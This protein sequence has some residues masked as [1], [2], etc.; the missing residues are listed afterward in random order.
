MA[1]GCGGAERGG[2][3]GASASAELLGRLAQAVGREAVA[4]YLGSGTRLEMEAEDLRIAVPNRFAAE[5]IER[6]M[7]DALRAASGGSVRYDILPEAPGSG[8][9]GHGSG[10]HGTG[11]GRGVAGRADADGTHAGC[12][13]AGRARCR[14]GAGSG[15]STLA[16]QR[17]GRRGGST[18]RSRGWNGETQTLEGFVVGPSNRFAYTAVTRIV[19]GMIPAGAGPVF[20]YGPCGVGKTH[21][22]NAAIAGFRAANPGSRTRIASAESFTNEFIGAIRS[23][24]IEAFHRRYRRVDLLCIDDVHFLA[25]K[26]GTQT[27]LLHTFDQIGIGG[28]R[29]VIASDEHPGR[30][31]RFSEALVSRFVSGSL[32]RIDRPDTETRGR[33]I[34]RF[35][36][37]VGVRF[38]AAAVAMIDAVAESESGRRG[39]SVRDLSGVV[40]RVAAFLTVMGG[41]DGVGAYGVE[42]GVVR[43]SGVEAAV[44]AQGGLVPGVVGDHDD[45]GGGGLGGGLGFV[46]GAGSGRAGSGGAGRC[47]P[48]LAQAVRPSGRSSGRPS[49]RP[50]PIGV[51]IDRVCDSLEVTREDLGSRGRHPRVVL[52][53]A[54]VAILARRLTRNSYPEIA[55]AIGRRNHSTVITAHRRIEKQIAEGQIVAVGLPE[56]GL[57]ISVLL[58]RIEREAR[59]S[60]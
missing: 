27:E 10:G 31:R 5:L 2:R 51:V 54:A 6:R 15:R 21:L 45:R 47:V 60:V 1:R 37:R 41:A 16:E 57:P 59:A 9:K 48:E 24:T 40:N 17:G 28:G 20:L 18:G 36:T 43:A 3:R 19:E 34:D 13:D 8:L 38:D 49:G 29:I 44:R 35:A 12:S 14:D 52:A 42:N 55:V 58:E 56:D 39:V 11:L 22:L 25:T 53:R 7:G 33:L 23:N 32:V 46:G 50:V 4:R 26:G 30:I